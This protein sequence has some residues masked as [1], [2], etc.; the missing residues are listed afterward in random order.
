MLLVFF[1]FFY[2]MYKPCLSSFWTTLSPFSSLFYLSFVS[3]ILILP[4]LSSVYSRLCLSQSLSVF[5]CLHLYLSVQLSFI[6]S[7]CCM[8]VFMNRV[9]KNEGALRIF[10]GGKVPS[11]NGTR[12]AGQCASPSPP[13]TIGTGH[14]TLTAGP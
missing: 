12:Q 5:L 4:L 7:P 9:S 8:Y 1:F 6:F 3:S 10:C 14:T 11:Y 2:F 13:S